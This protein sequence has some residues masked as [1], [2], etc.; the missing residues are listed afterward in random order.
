MSE[1]NHVISAPTALHRYSLESDTDSIEIRNRLHKGKGSVGIRFFPFSNDPAPAHFLIYDIPP[2]ASEGTHTHSHGDANE[3]AFDEYYY[4]VSGKG[5]MEIGD[6][7]VPVKAG[8]F[9]H[10]P[11]GTKHGIENTS[12]MENLKVFLTYIKRD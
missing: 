10:T 12:P 8:D 6:R 4:I 2:N 9:I 7:I 3:G 11:L 1:D 5:Q